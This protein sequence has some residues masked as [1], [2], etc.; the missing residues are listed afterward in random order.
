[1]GN[2]V[3]HSL[4]CS[5]GGSQTNIYIMRIGKRV[6]VPQFRVVV[7]E[8]GGVAAGDVCV[9]R[10]RARTTPTLA[11][12]GCVNQL[13]ARHW[14]AVRAGRPRAASER[15]SARPSCERRCAWAALGQ[16]NSMPEQQKSTHVPGELLV[17]GKRPTL[18]A[19]AKKDRLLRSLVSVPPPKQTAHQRPSLSTI[20]TITQAATSQPTI[21][22]SIPTTQQTH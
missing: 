20:H 2:E 9:R 8:D 1:V 7:L 5:L 21:C 17:L 6:T 13:L 4:T 16:S 10:M 3:A 14:F 11:S 19:S 12:E 22:I 18:A 15:V